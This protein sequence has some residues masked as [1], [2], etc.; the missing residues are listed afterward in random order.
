MELVLVPVLRARQGDSL[1]SLYHPPDPS[2]VKKVQG[3]RKGSGV[4]GDTAGHDPTGQ[5]NEGSPS[6]SRN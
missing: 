3:F 1:L 4:A 6:I 2:R 5:T